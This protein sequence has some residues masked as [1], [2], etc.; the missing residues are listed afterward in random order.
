M[1]RFAFLDHPG[2]L[3][4]A[5]RGGAL[6]AH[7]NT[8]AA[9]ERARKLGY[10]YMES[11]VHATA[12]GVVVAIHD[13]TLDRVANQPGVVRYMAWNELSAI[14]VG[15][16]QTPPRLDE[17]LCAWPELRWNL[18]VKHDS[19]VIPLAETLRLCGATDR[20]C[21]TSFND[22]RLAWTRQLVGPE[23]CSAAGAGAVAALLAGSTL[24]G[25][26]GVLGARLAARTFS[27]S[28]P[29]GAVQVPERWGRVRIV[30][31]RFV[32]A[33]HAAGL[34]VHVWTVD[35][36][37]DMG[38]L[39]DLGVDGIMTDRPSVLAEVLR[40]R[41]AWWGGPGGSDG[42]AAGESGAGGS[43]AG[44]SGAGGSSAGESGAGGSGAGGSGAGGSGAGE[45]GAGESGAGGSGA[46][47][48]ARPA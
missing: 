43:G 30:D 48:S 25:A 15:A 35:D 2:P 12:D 31:H 4:F 22:R 38:R 20:V 16:D 39:L 36:E 8:W 9:F 17:L 19:A 10:I 1:T 40:H 47:G 5:H 29:F 46:G 23:V 44:G 34:Q 21:I 32:S 18:D 27:R 14:R 7:E 24:P 33:M 42:P 11:D 3:A 6:E 45:S 26:A 28:T 41:G 13:P 37:A